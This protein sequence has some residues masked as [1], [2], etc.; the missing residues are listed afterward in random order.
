MAKATKTS[1][2]D[3]VAVVK[4]NE[5]VAS[6]IFSRDGVQPRSQKALGVRGLTEIVKKKVSD[7]PALSVPPHFLVQ[8][9]E[10]MESEEWKNH[11]LSKKERLFVRPCPITPRHGFVESREIQTDGNG[12]AIGM[13]T[14]ILDEARAADPESEVLLSEPIDSKWSAIWTP[15]HLSFGEGHDGATSGN[16]FFRLS[17]P[18]IN[19]FADI[20]S[21]Y[22]V[23]A[24]DVPYL[25]LLVSKDADTGQDGKLCIVQFR[26]G[27]KVGASGPNIVP[28]DTLVTRVFEANGSLLDY[29]KLI[30]SL[31]PGDVVYKLGDS[32]ISHYAAHCVAHKVPYITDHVPVIGEFIAKSSDIPEFDIAALRQGLIEGYNINIPSK[33]AL[34][35]VAKMCVIVTHYSQFFRTGDSAVTL[36]RFC[37]LLV[38]ISSALCLNETKYCHNPDEVGAGHLK[39]IVSKYPEGRNAVYMAHVN[40]P[41]V[42]RGLLRDALD[43]FMYGQWGGGYGGIKWGNCSIHA[44]DLDNLIA[45]I[46]KDDG[47][48]QPDSYYQNLASKISMKMHA[49]VNACHNGGKLL[50]KVI[51]NSFLDKAASGNSK[52]SLEYIF[53]YVHSVY[54]KRNTGF[55]P[56]DS[57]VYNP[58]TQAVTPAKSEKWWAGTEWMSLEDAVK[59]T[60]DSPP[61]PEPVAAPE[62]E[63]IKQYVPEF[64]LRAQVRKYSKDNYRIQVNWN[65]LNWSD[66]PKDMLAK[67]PTLKKQKSKAD[68]NI[69]EGYPAALS[70]QGEYN[71]EDQ[72]SPGYGNKYV[73]NS[74]GNAENNVGADLPEETEKKIVEE[75]IQPS[76]AG[77]GLKYFPMQCKWWGEDFRF[78]ELSVDGVVMARFDTYTK[79]IQ[80]TGGW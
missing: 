2:P 43:A 69:P 8:S 16:N 22:N 78:K 36:G 52:M 38:R 17:L 41:L 40:N 37:S 24:P 26:G 27:P 66:A 49:L 60:Q 42:L 34:D 14:A 70:G 73:G 6:I 15:D 28:H 53:K 9:R 1:K 21:E 31:K 79:T 55:I 45:E 56:K 4:E 76:N 32:P 23:H 51:S 50:T 13:V 25:E 11:D 58:S 80:S 65:H 19:P 20:Q 39:A 7:F 30:K 63:V 54:E 44:V 68:D 18:G 47:W 35:E 46:L 59:L 3:P 10:D 29:E 75:A 33:A 74:V 64:D 71:E 77:T 67:K 62:P 57:V 61:K 72:Y 12:K 48:N 5:A